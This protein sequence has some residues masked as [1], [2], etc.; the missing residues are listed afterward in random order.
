MV[1]LKKKTRPNSLNSVAAR[2]G[3]LFKKNTENSYRF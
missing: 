3:I 1:I 2:D